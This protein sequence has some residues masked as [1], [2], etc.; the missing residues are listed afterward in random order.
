MTKFL[1]DSHK[2]A[3]NELM[4]RI[5]VNGQDIERVALAYLF[6]LD[7][8]CRKHI[9]ELYDFEDGCIRCSALGAEWQT[10][11]SLKTSRLAFNLFTGGTIWTE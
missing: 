6:T 11:T 1:D 9:N 5:G 2:E 4:Q 10:G 7:T 8:V 3:Y